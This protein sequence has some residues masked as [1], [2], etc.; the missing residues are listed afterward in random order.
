MEIIVEREQPINVSLK[1]S[2]PIINVQKTNGVNITLESE[3]IT[4][5]LVKKPDIIFSFS[6]KIIGSTEGS[7]VDLSNYYTRL[8][9]DNKFVN[10]SEL[11]TTHYTKQETDDTFVKKD[12]LVEDIEPTINEIG[13]KVDAVEKTLQDDYYDK[14]TINTTFVKGEELAPTIQE[15]NK[16]F[17]GVST[18]L[19]NRVT[20]EEANATFTKKEDLPLEVNT[21]TKPQ[22]DQLLEKIDK[23]Y[24]TKEQT[25]NLISEFGKGNIVCTQEAYDAI[26]NKENIFYMIKENDDLQ[27]IYFGTTLVWQKKTD[28]SMG[29]PYTFPFKLT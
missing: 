25:D 29:F 17:A 24:Y 6:A 28:G 19:N 23:D 2:N 10:K 7:S 13:T 1:S 4:F 27:K 26:V 22:F 5:R 20:K 11:E 8:Q 15:I 12:D 14:E 18:E 9:T 16:A 21:I 3:N